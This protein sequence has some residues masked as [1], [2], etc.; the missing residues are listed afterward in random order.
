MK[1]KLSIAIP[2]IDGSVTI[3]RTLDS[4]VLQAGDNVEIVISDNSSDNAT[5]NVIRDYQLRFPR[6]YYFANGKNLG[7]DRNV[8]LCVRRSNADFVWFFADD[9]FMREGAIATV[10]NIINM[11]PEVCEVYVDSLKPYTVLEEDRLC[12]SG[13]DFFAITKYRC[14]GVSSNVVN[15]QIWESIDLSAY[16]D[17]GWIHVAYLVIALS[18]YPSSIFVRM[19]LY[20]S[21]D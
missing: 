3:K 12:N 5:Y 20:L 8:D 17:L 15:K 21:S 11:H 10:L 2:T 1:P 14:G 6:I 9:D 13:D 19:V 16:L 7:F 18:K 4:I